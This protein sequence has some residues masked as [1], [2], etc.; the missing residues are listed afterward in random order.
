MCGV[1]VS[2]T[3]WLALLTLAVT[4]LVW[5]ESVSARRLAQATS[6][7]TE[8]ATTNSRYGLPHRLSGRIPKSRFF[9]VCLVIAVAGVG[10]QFMPWPVAVVLVAI[11]TAAALAIVR[12]MRRRSAL[13]E[14]T[15]AIEGLGILVAELRAGRTASDA[16]G[17]AARHCGHAAVGDRLGRLGRSLRLGDEM[18]AST[19]D[20][21]APPDSLGQDHRAGTDWLPALRAGLRLSQQTGCALAD[22]LAAVELDISARVEQGADMRSASSGHRATAFLLAGLP[23]L[24]LAMGSGIGA[25][26]I[27]ILTRTSIGHVLLLLGVGLELLGLAWS[28]RLMR[29]AAL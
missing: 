7:V 18:Q 24:G 1:C 3:S 12:A 23:I 29:R 14:E 15:A 21:R 4:L 2:P 25:E 10:S 28:G 16:L 19:L 13:R 27:G 20:S 9:R 22:V 26:P 5:P 11:L 17:T 6:S 8:A